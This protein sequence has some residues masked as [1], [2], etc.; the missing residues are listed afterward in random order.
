MAGISS[1]ALNGVPENKYLYNG[2]ELQHKEFSD[3]NGLEWYDYGARM[4]DPQIGRWFTPDPLTENEY[5]NGLNESL[6]QVINEE[7]LGEDEETIE[8]VKSYAEKY[9]RI[10]RPVNLTAES[11][12]IHYNEGQYVYV[13]NNPIRYVDP[14][15]MDTLPTVTFTYVKPQPP[16]TWWVGPTLSGLGARFDF[17]K[18]VAALGSEKGSSIASKT[19]AKVIPTRFTKVLGKKA[20]TVIAKKAGTNV[21]G[22]FIGRLAG[23]VGAILVYKDIAV[24]TW[25]SF[26]HFQ[27]LSWQQQSHFVNS[28][29]MS[30]SGYVK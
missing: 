17:L 7:G 29:M 30:G 26:K 6:K 27:T 11:S 14:F 22:R 15:G 3:G 21:I 8:E 24:L 2:K 9:L 20:G 16:S 28:Q 23:P 4:M 25:Q 13:L 19:L 1:K 10:L 18:P 12:A 5:E